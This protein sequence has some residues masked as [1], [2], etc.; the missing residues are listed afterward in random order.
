[1]NSP[2]GSRESLA[3][4]N[5]DSPQKQDN[6]SMHDEHSIASVGMKPFTNIHMLKTVQRISELVSIK[7]IMGYLLA[8]FKEEMVI[9]R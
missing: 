5:D 7:N 2:Y 1:M 4:K 9:Q 3:S 8:L 6:S